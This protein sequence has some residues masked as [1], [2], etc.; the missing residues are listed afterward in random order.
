MQALPPLIVAVP[1]LAAVILAAAGKRLARRVLDSVA[2]GVSGAVI[3]MS[4]VLLHET[5]GGTSVYWFGGWHA[6]GH[7]ALGVSFTVDTFGAGVAVFASV[8]IFFA[9]LFSWHYFETVGDLYHVLVLVFLSAMLGMGLTGDLFNL[10][11]FFELLSV[12]AIALAGYRV[13]ESQPLQGALN[14][15][16]TNTLAALLILTGIALLYARTGALNLAQI[17]RVLGQQTP[18]GLVIAAFTLLVAGFF[19][20]AAI[21]PFHFWLADAYGSAPTPVCLVMSGVMS[22][23]GLYAMARLYWSVFQEGFSPHLA[24]LRSVLIVTGVITAVAGGLMCFAQHHLKRQL[25]FATVAH[26]GLYLIGLGF[27]TRIGLGAVAV[28]AVADG[29]VKASLFVCSGILL[30]R[31]SSVD[32]LNLYGR[33]RDL[34]VTALLVLAGALALAGLPPFGTFVGKTLIEEEAGVVGWGWLS[35]VYAGVSMLTAAATLRAGARIFLGWGPRPTSQTF[36]SDP[37]TEQAAEEDEGTPETSGEGKRTPLVMVTSAAGLLLLS[38]LAG[39]SGGLAHGVES[40][41]AR[42]ADAGYYRAV[43]LSSGHHAAPVV[44]RASSALTSGIPAAALS[45][46]G[47]FILSGLGLYRERLPSGLRA[48]SLRFASRPLHVL[49][50]LHSGHVGDYVAWLMLGTALLG[51][52]FARALI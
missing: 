38:L 50:T 46:A 42:F 15:A 32:E 13:E 24:A 37:F 14:F 26:G 9:F 20:K 43:V 19:I 33:G 48:A 12:S 41:S 4:L 8:L 21:V 27:L 10:F 39:L 2:L 1:L 16:I 30:S 36:A 34:K 17:G 18:D 7:V 5:L 49:R 6:S 40:A 29:L 44:H 51:A 25:A 35:L 52:A 31:R 28:Y 23:L 22:E 11:V 3:V 47:A 45:V